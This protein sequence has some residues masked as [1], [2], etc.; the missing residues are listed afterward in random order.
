MRFQRKSTVA[1]MFRNF[2]QLVYVTLPVSVLIAFFYNPSSEISLFSSLVKGEIV[3]EN[4]LDLLTKSLTVLRFGKHW[5]VVLCAI[6]LLAVTMSLMV[7]KLD[8]HMRMGKMPA[9]PVRRALGIFHFMLM[10]IVGWLAVTEL[11]ILVIVGICYM[12]R[13]IG[14]AT[15][16]VSIALGLTFGV[17]VFLTYMFG[18]LVIAFPLKYSENY[19][20]NI[21]MSY[22]ARTMSSKRLQLVGLAFLYPTAR[23]AVMAIAYLLEPVMLDV[24]VYAVMLTL[25]LMFV[26]CFAFKKFYDDVGGE[27][28]DLVQI[29]F[30]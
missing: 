25:C 11:C 19:R 14:N 6:V 26:P 13:F 12:V 17:R 30:D 3:M 24:L 15:A 27:R 8:R 28:R 4:Y 7:V 18:L 29:M 21:A 2:G 16:I 10:Y 1:Y 20:F 22:S 5:W 9:L 23:I